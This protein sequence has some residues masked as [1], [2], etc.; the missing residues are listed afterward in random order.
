M[1]GQRSSVLA[2]LA[3]EAGVEPQVAP[4]AAAYVL[5]MAVA[6]PLLMRAADRPAPA[7]A[8]TA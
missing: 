1:I 7:L 6:G 5:I 8:R 4:M 3:S 2:R